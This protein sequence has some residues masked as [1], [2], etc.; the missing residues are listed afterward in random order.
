MGRTA[1]ARCLS[2]VCESLEEI[3]S[4]SPVY[5]ERVNTECRKG[6]NCMTVTLPE[7]MFSLSESA[8]L[9]GCNRSHMYWLV[10]NNHIASERGESG[11]LRISKEALYHYL[12]QREQK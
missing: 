1:K 4:Y 2:Q 11:Q 8:K 3:V 5:L 12:M 9:I 6:G 7:P 10:K